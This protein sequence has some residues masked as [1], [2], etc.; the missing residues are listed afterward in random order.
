MILAVKTAVMD[1]DAANACTEIHHQDVDD[2]MQEP[3]T[4][5][6]FAAAAFTFTAT[7]ALVQQHWKPPPP[8]PDESLAWRR[9]T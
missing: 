5:N 3:A 2:A 8:S 4:L 1:T 6:Y 7:W 9:R